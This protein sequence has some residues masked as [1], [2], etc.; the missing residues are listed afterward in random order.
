MASMAS[1]HNSMNFIG[2]ISILDRG[3][4]P[5]Q[6]VLDRNARTHAKRVSNETKEELTQVMK[7]VDNVCDSFEEGDLPETGTL[8]QSIYEGFDLQETLNENNRLANTEYVT[9]VI[10]LE[11]I[12]KDN[13]K[14]KQYQQQV[15]IFIVGYENAC[16]QKLKLLQQVN[17]FFVENTKDDEDVD[18]YAT[19]QEIDLDEVSSSIEE[20]LQYTEQLAN[21]LGDINSDIVEYLTNYAHAKASNKG[22]KKLE[23]AL[24]QAKEDIGNLSEKLL[25]TQQEIEEKEEKMQLLYRQTEMKN[26]EIQRLKLAADAAKKSLEDSESLKTEL[27]NRDNLIRELRTKVDQLTIEKDTM[28]AARGELLNRLKDAGEDNLGKIEDLQREMDRQYLEAENAKKEGSVSASTQPHSENTHHH[29]HL[30]S[31]NARLKR[32][33][34]KLG[35]STSRDE[36]ESESDTEIPQP[37]TVRNISSREIKRPV[38][39]SIAFPVKPVLLPGVSPVQRSDSEESFFITSQPIQGSRPNSVARSSERSTPRTSRTP[40][41]KHREILTYERVKHL[42]KRL[43]TPPSLPRI[44]NSRIGTPARYL[45]TTPLLSRPPTQCGA[46]FDAIAEL[47][48]HD[49]SCDFDFSSVASDDS[50]GMKR[51]ADI[52]VLDGEEYGVLPLGEAEVQGL[53]DELAGSNLIGGRQAEECDSSDT[54]CSDESESEESD[55]ELGIEAGT[56]GRLGIEGDVGD[57]PDNEERIDVV[58]AVSVRNGS[59]ELR[60][61]EENSLDS[62]SE[63]ETL[64]EVATNPMCDENNKVDHDGPNKSIVPMET[65]V[66]TKETDVAIATSAVVKETP[67]TEVVDNSETSSSETDT[68]SEE[69]SHMTA[70]TSSTDS[71]DTSDS[72]SSGPRSR[73]RP[74]KV[75]SVQSN[76]QKGQQAREGHS[77]GKGSPDGSR[78]NGTSRNVSASLTGQRGALC[79][80]VDA[81]RPYTSGGSGF[82]DQ[83]VWFRADVRKDGRKI[84]FERNGE[85]DLKNVWGGVGQKTTLSPGRK[86]SNGFREASVMQGP[87]TTVRRPS[88]PVG[89]TSTSGDVLRDLGRTENDSKLGQDVR[90]SNNNRN[91]SIPVG[92]G[93]LTATNKK[94]IK[95]KTIADKKGSAHH[96]PVPPIG[97]RGS[98]TYDAGQKFEKSTRGG[99]L[100]AETKSTRDTI[101]SGRVLKELRNLIRFHEDQTIQ[102]SKSHQQKTDELEEEHVLET[103][104]L[105]DKVKDLTEQLEDEKRKNVEQE[106]QIEEL[107]TASTNLSETKSQP[108]KTKTK[109]KPVRNI[110]KFKTRDSRPNTNNSKSKKKG[111]GASP[112]ENEEEEEADKSRPASHKSLQQVKEEVMT[113]DYS[114][115]LDAEEMWADVPSNHVLGRFTQFRELA[116]ARISELE[117]QLSDTILKTQRKVNTLKG[118]FQEHKSKWEAE[119]NVLIEQIDQSQKLQNVAEKE[120]DVAM[121]QLEDFI[122]EQEELE[123]AE[124]EKRKSRASATPAPPVVATPDVGEQP[125]NLQEVTEDAEGEDLLEQTDDAKVKELHAKLKEKDEDERRQTPSP[126]GPGKMPNQPHPMVD[127]ASDTSANIVTSARRLLEYEG[128]YSYLKDGA[129]VNWV[130]DPS[131]KYLE[132]SPIHQRRRLLIV[133]ENWEVAKKRNRAMVKK[134]NEIRQR[135]DSLTR[136]KF[137][138]FVSRKPILE[139]DGG[140]PLESEHVSQRVRGHPLECGREHTLQRDRDHSLDPEGD[141]I[142]DPVVPDRG[143]AIVGKHGETTPSSRE[144]I[145]SKYRESLEETRSAIAERRSK[146]PALSVKSMKSSLDDMEIDENGD[147]PFPED[148]TFADIGTS[149][150]TQKGDATPSSSILRRPLSL[151]SHSAQSVFPPANEI[152]R[153][154]TA[155]S[156]LTSHTNSLRTTPY[157]NHTTTLASTPDLDR[158]KTPNLD[159]FAPDDN[160]KSLTLAEHPVVQEYLKT[161]DTVMAF[162]D[163]LGKILAEKDMTSAGQV[164]TEMEPYAFNV[165]EKVQPQ[166]E[167]MTRNVV[168]IFEEMLQMLSGVIL[169]KGPYSVDGAPERSFLTKTD[170]GHTLSRISRHSSDSVGDAKTAAQIKDL[171]E[172]LMKL[173]MMMGSQKEQYEEKL[174][175]NTVVMM[176]MQDT[177]NG[178]RREMST[179]GIQTRTP[180]AAPLQPVG[181]PI[182][183]TRL[184]SERNSK[185]MK[186]AVM[187]KKLE[188]KKYQAAVEKMDEYVNIP[189][190]RLAH[191]VRKYTHHCQMKAIEANV[192]LSRSLNDEVFH[193]L[194]KMEQLQNRRAQKW[195]ERMDGMGSERLRLA[196]LLMEVL[197]D[198]EMESGIFLIKPMYSYKGRE[199]LNLYANRQSR[200]HSQKFRTASPLPTA[201]TNASSR[202]FGLAPAPTPAS[203][204]KHDREMESVMREEVGKLYSQKT[205]DGISGASLGYVTG[206]KTGGMWNSSLSQPKAL[207]ED[208]L[209]FQSSILNTPRILELDVNRMMIGQNQISAKMRGSLGDDRLMNATQTNL[210]NYV[211]VTRPTNSSTPKKEHPKSGSTTVPPTTPYMDRKGSGDG[212]RGALPRDTVPLPPISPTILKEKTGT[213]D[214]PS[215]PTSPPRSPPGSSLRETPPQIMEI[216]VEAE[217]PPER[218][219]METEE[220]IT[221]NNEEMTYSH[222]TKVITRS[223]SKQSVN[224]LEVAESDYYADGDED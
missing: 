209:L 16:I 187:T 88:A 72:D 212:H 62:N 190:Q 158:I 155:G 165:A 126:V 166:V 65:D 61:S 164:L 128:F 78:L 222:I 49:D 73:S 159:D 175:H 69:E 8:R 121:A 210:R 160:G 192:R 131:E 189:A 89:K 15:T 156:A 34:K 140:H 172:Q 94:V 101:S 37:D 39:K 110:P 179:I 147:M 60:S 77:V 106:L 35:L 123:V 108:A 144:T 208:N 191:L 104:H 168:Q 105:K 17:E 130:S 74:S 137:S 196:Q 182:M 200:A 12:L 163:T 87:L 139:R 75:R 80:Q 82:K 178:L 68:D 109:P 92:Q 216:T 141:R 99:A 91:N 4:A 13:L 214:V 157:N 36:S 51:D 52:L 207:T 54:N 151:Q 206:E 135:A 48:S 50:V 184:D 217:I 133:G 27:G 119:R 81:Q 176:E 142:L 43:P 44:P 24:Y 220:N 152:V 173:E 205:D 203:Q 2:G 150:M 185:V 32:I 224:T 76:S 64:P 58:D 59:K 167:D 146:S 195:A 170:T 113:F 6:E 219:A 223:S 117:E 53:D 145:R 107:K 67:V 118:Q 136:Q 102:M 183:F 1:M 38:T 46:V 33:D 30:N 100:D 45:I 5:A 181:S 20:S 134:L 171:Q 186:K 93:G 115:D 9:D 103:K 124:D 193:I 55:G 84:G 112:S 199:Y 138:H 29:F 66:V 14:K 21:K 23:K 90:N 40:V 161:Y 122:N 85:T 202:A 63:S 153:S 41:E 180:S 83:A 98:G 114:Y 3:D 96:V 22:K 7:R 70:S 215:L 25:H 132:I 125:E 28:E 169:S 213:K 162:K 86:S 56:G 194:D 174:N 95:E 111:K 97:R 79:M 19:E 198:I 57:D 47:S 26:M 129:T 188:T 127:Y 31:A 221:N 11:E 204:L 116:R 42:P 177:I 18:V 149:P 71:S 197:D 10:E 120:A 211:T 143:Q 154:E 201:R 218:V 148:K